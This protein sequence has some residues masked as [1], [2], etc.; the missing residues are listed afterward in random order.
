MDPI[1]QK[2][3]KKAKKKSHQCKYCGKASL[4]R[5]L[6]RSHV[7]NSHEQSLECK[8]CGKKFGYPSQLKI[9]LKAV[10][11]KRKDFKCEICVD[12]SFGQKSTLNHHLK[13]HLKTSNFRISREKAMDL[14]PT[15]NPGSIFSHADAERMKLQKKEKLQ[16]SK[17]SP[18]KRKRNMY[19]ETDLIIASKKGNF[20]KMQS[21]L[22]DPKMEIDVNE[23]DYN[24]WT[25]L[26][27]AAKDGR[28]LWDEGQKLNVFV[29]RI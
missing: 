15:A 20:A 24:H 28:T 4:T 8:V 9:H 14:D 11:E 26:H 19:G 23:E 29:L 18:P 10:H 17:N 3:L 5:P 21:L 25:S 7:R 2:T 22:Q 12:K 1:D 6:L 27:E 13:I 16:P